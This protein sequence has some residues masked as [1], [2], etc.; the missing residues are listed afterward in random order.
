MNSSRSLIVIITLI[1]AIA[2]G[3]TSMAEAAN[4]IVEG[5]PLD[6]STSFGII[7]KAGTTVQALSAN[8]ARMVFGETFI[9][10]GTSGFVVRSDCGDLHLRK[11][12]DAL[13]VKAPQFLRVVNFCENQLE[14]IRVSKSDRSFALPAGSEAIIARSRRALDQALLSQCVPRRSISIS[15]LPDSWLILRAECEPLSSLKS[16]DSGRVILENQSKMRRILKIAASL[17]CVTSARGR[18]KVVHNVS[19]CESAL[20]PVDD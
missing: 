5:T 9:S 15:E 4:S 7:K 6:K 19:D 1:T 10:A 13:V 17:V 8:C 3:T 18:Y 16:S 2:V 14:S 11:N 12:T 20:A